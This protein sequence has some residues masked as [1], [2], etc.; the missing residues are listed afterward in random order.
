MKQAFVILLLLL[1]SSCMRAEQYMPSEVPPHYKTGS[2][3]TEKGITS[4]PLKSSQGYS[5][6]GIASW[7]GK[8]FHGRKTANGERYDMYAMSAAHRTLPLP[9]MVRVT[10]RENGR[11]IVVRVND[12]GPFIEGRL[13]DLSYAAARELGFIHQ[14]TAKVKIE[15]IDSVRDGMALMPYDGYM[16]LKKNIYILLESYPELDQARRLKRIIVDD[17]PSTHIRF[18]KKSQQSDARYYVRLGPFHNR[19]QLEETLLKLDNDHIHH[20]LEEE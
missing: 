17:Y 19:Q 20:R 16:P 2:K 1:L 14:G 11:Q 9:T 4:T 12:R 13:I 8:K 6:K 5:A 7:Y 10:N 3:Y 18:I 15:V